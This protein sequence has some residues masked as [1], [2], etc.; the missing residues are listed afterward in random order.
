[1]FIRPL[2]NDASFLLDIRKCEKQRETQEIGMQKVE[3]PEELRGREST[4]YRF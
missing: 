1:M 3:E 2:R 4:F